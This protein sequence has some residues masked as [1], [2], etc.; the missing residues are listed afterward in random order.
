MRPLNKA[1]VPSGSLEPES[2]LEPMRVKLKRLPNGRQADNLVIFVFEGGSA[3]GW[4]AREE[5]NK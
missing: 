2:T 3:L 1:G 4:T 5:M